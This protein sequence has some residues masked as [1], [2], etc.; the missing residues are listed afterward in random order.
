M[1]SRQQSYNKRRKPRGIVNSERRSSGNNSR[2]AVNVLVVTALE[3]LLNPV[4]SASIQ[5]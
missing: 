1:K 2:A 4:Y 3:D 5:S